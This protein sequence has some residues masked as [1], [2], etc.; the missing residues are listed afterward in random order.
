MTRCGIITGWA[1]IGGFAVCAA[2]LGDINHNVRVFQ[3]S[4]ALGFVGYLLLLWIVTRCPDPARLGSWRWWLLGCIAVR[5][6]C[7]TTTPGDDA[8]R[9]VW[10][11]RVQ[12]A[13]I[14]PYAKSPMDV[15]LEH[16]RDDDW[17][18]INHPDYSAIYPPLAQ[19]Q[20]ALAAFI[21]PSIHTVKTLHVLW[22][23]L[24]VA[25]LGGCLRRA[26]RK[27]HEAIL[28]GLCPLVLT[29][30]GIEGHLDSLMLL[31]LV[32]TV[33]A[34]Q[35]KRTSIAGA[36]LGAAIATKILPIVLWPWFAL[37]HPR[38]AAIAIGVVAISC[39]PYVSAGGDLLTSLGRFSQKS[40]FFSFLGAIGVTRFG[41][42]LALIAMAAALIGVVWLLAHRRK[43]FTHFALGASSATILLMPVVHYWYLA[44]VIVFAAFHRRASWILAALAMVFYF[45][46]AHMA[47]T[48][49]WTMPPWT[50]LVVWG[51]FIAGALVDVATRRGR[52]SA[53]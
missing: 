30:F 47:T 6:I 49:T 50:P 27:P 9:Y 41:T 23:V 18:K 11:G 10:E 3:A 51:A 40:E 31:W 12:L 52:R 48:G 19:A 35:T 28:Y 21:Q 44:M 38:A 42:R 25:L 13:G 43:T 45:E 7:I 20:F 5:A 2:W 36:L 53:P 26:G 1:L 22:D 15:D 29:A 32:G 4:Y 8:Y 14:N 33:W 46:A 17:A 34:V 39:L 16:L 24:V 37:R